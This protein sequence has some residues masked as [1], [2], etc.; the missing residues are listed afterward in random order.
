M[1]ILVTG[2][3]GFIGSNLVEELAKDKD[4][5][6]IVID[7]LS[8]TSRNVPLLKK[9]GVEFYKMDIGNFSEIKDVFAGIDT[10]FHLAAMNRAQRS[11]QNPLEANK[12]NIDG[13]INCLESAKSAGVGRFVF[14]SSSS[15]YAGQKN[16]LLTEDM[17]LF[18]LHPYG[19]GKLAGEHY[20]R[21]YYSLYGLRTIILRFFSVY[22]PRQLGDIDNA[23]VIPKFI[24]AIINDRP[25][26]VYGD[27][28]QTRNFTFVK[29]VVACAIEASRNEKTV[30][31]V[32]NIASEDEVSVNQILMEISKRLHKKPLIEYQPS[33]KGDPL[34]NPADIQKAKT[35]LGRIPKIKIDEGIRITVEEYLK[36]SG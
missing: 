31:D 10:V 5:K 13:T 19:V 27:G 15:V 28:E 12:T 17:P 11:I 9:W 33:L 3:A 6:I 22:G 32:F 29:D 18:P 26:E 4:N 36:N 16:K 1:K 30:G 35:I 7:N 8:V 24:D 21:I 34:R 20:A 25:V 23:A 14:V 2:G